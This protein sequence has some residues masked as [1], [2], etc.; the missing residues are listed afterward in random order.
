[1]INVKSIKLPKIHLQNLTAAE[2]MDYI[3]TDMGGIVCRNDIACNGGRC[4]DA[5]T[6]HH[7]V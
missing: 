1:M 6:C 7:R 5:G 3:E 4:D 2:R